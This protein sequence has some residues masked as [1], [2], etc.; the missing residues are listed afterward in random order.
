MEIEKRIGNVKSMT[1]YRK[2]AV[3]KSPSENEGLQK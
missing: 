2:Y 1:P 3:M